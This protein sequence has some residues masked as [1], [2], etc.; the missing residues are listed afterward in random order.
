MRREPLEQLI[1]EV[2]HS[3]SPNSRDLGK[4]RPDSPN[5]RVNAIWH[6]GHDDSPS[7][8]LKSGDT[9]GRYPHNSDSVAANEERAVPHRSE[10]SRRSLSAGRKAFLNSR[11]TVGVCLGPHTRIKAPS[12]R[13]F[14]VRAIGARQMLRPISRMS[15]VRIK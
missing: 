7:H 1:G 3:K 5:P 9:S 2:D 14:A 15:L 11:S 8:R 13:I 10:D 12:E 6:A 4:L